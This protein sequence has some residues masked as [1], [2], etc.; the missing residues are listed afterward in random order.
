MDTTIATST[1]LDKSLIS[2]LL[3]EFRTA[4]ANGDFWT[5]QQLADDTRLARWDSQTDDGKK[6]DSN[7]PEGQPA[8]PWDGASD[9][10][11]YQSDEV[12]NESV[13]TKLTAFWRADVRVEGVEAG[14]LS[15]A[16]SATTFMEWMRNND[17]RDGL[18]DD[19]E[20]SAQYEEWYGWTALHVSWERLLSYKWRTIDLQA[21]VQL[22]QQFQGMDKLPDENMDVA[23]HILA[24]PQLVMD[25]DREA[26]AINST[27]FLYRVY[28]NQSLPQDLQ[29]TDIPDISTSR[30]RTVVR[31]LRKHGRSQ[32]PFPYLCK[33]KPCITALK[34]WRDIVVPTDTTD[35]QGARAIFIRRFMTEA[36]VRSMVKSDEWDSAFVEE[37]IQTKGRL[38]VWSFSSQG[39]LNPIQQW[40]FT[41]QRNNLIE[42]IIAYHK[43]VDDDGMAAVYYT[44]FSAHLME[45][46][47]KD[48]PSVAKTGMLEDSTD[49]Y[50]IVVSR[51]E[52][53][54]RQVMACRGVP[55]ILLTS[56]RE[57]KVLRDSVMD[58]CSIGVIPPLNIYKGTMGQRYKFAPKAENMV[59]PG[60]EPKLM[61]ISGQ[62]PQFAIEYLQTVRTNVDHYFG[63]VREDV[64]PQ[65]SQMLLEPRIRRFLCAWSKALKM[66]FCLYQRYAPEMFERVTGQ[67]SPGEDAAKLDFLFHFDIA[68]L[69]PEAM[70]MKLNAFSALLPEDTVG[71][72]DRSALIRAKARMIDPSLARELVMDQGSASQQLFDK[73]KGDLIGMSD[74]NEGSYTDAANDPT[75]QARSQ[76]IKQIVGGNIKYLQRLDPQ[77]IQQL[78]IQVPPQLQQTMGQQGQQQVD[79]IFSSLLEKYIKNISLAQSQQQNKQIGRIGVAQ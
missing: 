23:A 20:L 56:Q 63:R 54:D 19:V 76:Y 11:C 74:G 5:R 17:L 24:Y 62:G 8:F 10:R 57:E 14:D 13:A 31:D 28:V 73:V 33:N 53:L 42:I 55:E 35:L 43:A 6:H 30:A 64:P 61:E 12:I 37:V 78:G 39:L 48:V 65:L 47:S 18:E 67:P 79:P 16:S 38:S 34:P 44:I 58:W 50:P 49:E 40:S 9:V 27:K 75:A 29:E 59:T 52:L 70:E 15:T 3:Q 2:Q 68:Q 45:G 60:R 36:E 66:A 72:L 25:P 7:L 69:N 71:V 77:L 26:I 22:S 46:E 41:S 21:L 1:V 4:G 51:R 32:I